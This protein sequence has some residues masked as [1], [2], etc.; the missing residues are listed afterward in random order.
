ME[1]KEYKAGDIVEHK[2]MRGK[3]VLIKYLEYPSM[4]DWRVRTE[5]GELLD[6]YKVEIKE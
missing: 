5:S 1:E 4:T 2:V 3:M 6:I